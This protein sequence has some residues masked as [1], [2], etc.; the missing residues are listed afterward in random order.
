MSGQYYATNAI[1]LK[2]GQRGA[3][4]SY[5]AGAPTGDCGAVTCHVSG[6][7]GSFFPVGTDDGSPVNVANWVGQLGLTV[8]V[9]D[10]G[11]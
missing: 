2:A 9:E 11:D 8:T 6:S 4:L 1:R 5:D 10:V 3:H 7:A